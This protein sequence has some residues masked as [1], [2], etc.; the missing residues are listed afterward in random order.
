MSVLL[1]CFPG[2]LFSEDMVCYS[3]CFAGLLF[4]LLF[5][6]FRSIYMMGKKGNDL[7][8]RKRFGK[9]RKFVVRVPFQ[10]MLCP[11]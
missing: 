11:R 4:D 5:L 7:G 1:T 2:F 3:V 9:N 10:D 8:K 6:L